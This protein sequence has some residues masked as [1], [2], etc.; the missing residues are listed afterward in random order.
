MNMIAVSRDYFRRNPENVERMVRAYS[1]GVAAMN[2][3]KERALKVIAK[4][5]RIPDPKGIEDHY[6]DSVTYL[7]RVPK[8]ILRQF[9]PYLNSW[10][11][12]GAAGDLYGQLDHRRANPR[13]FFREAL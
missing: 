12:R 13:R 2:R 1:E 3:Q 10:A 5:G 9:K 4:Y 11:R 7:E 6:N 8:R